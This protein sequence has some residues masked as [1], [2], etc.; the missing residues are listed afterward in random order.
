MQPRSRRKQ[1]SSVNDVIHYECMID[2]FAYSVYRTLQV[3]K[4]S[5]KIPESFGHSIF[6][7]KLQP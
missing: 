7:E 3:W 4:I 5:G 2:I 1:A 6:L